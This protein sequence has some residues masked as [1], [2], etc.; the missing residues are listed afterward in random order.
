M[1]YKEKAVNFLQ[2]VVAGKIKEAYAKYIGEDLVHH[3]AYFPAGAK[4]LLQAMEDNARICPYQTLEVQQVI[5]EDNMVVVHSKIKKDEN[6]QGW[7]GVHI[8]K[9]KHEMIV[10]LWDV[11][12]QIPEN[13]PNKDG[14][15]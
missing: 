10:E 4:A 9:F 12:Q 1:D 14:I 3:N 2:M 13:L 15:F 11:I 6:D 7:A 5:R 8:F